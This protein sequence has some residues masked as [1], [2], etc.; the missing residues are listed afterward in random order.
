MSRPFTKLVIL[1]NVPSSQ[2]LLWV[3]SN[4]S[5]EPSRLEIQFQN[6]EIYQSKQHDIIAY[7]RTRTVA[8]HRFN[9]NNSY[10]FY[11][12]PNIWLSYPGIARGRSSNPPP[13]QTDSRE[14]TAVL[15]CCC[16]P[17]GL[18]LLLIL[19][20]TTYGCSTIP[21][22]STFV[23][24]FPVILF[25]PNDYITGV[26]AIT[27]PCGVRKWINCIVGVVRCLSIWMQQR[28]EYWFYVRRIPFMQLPAFK[29]LLPPNTLC[30]GYD[31]WYRIWC[32]IL[33]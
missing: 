16:F 32:S 14:Y 13:F 11:V 2:T 24:R 6:A 17:N 9:T 1:K 30:K 28:V 18:L 27:L 22:Q 5:S 31:N 12:K 25:P 29:L 20:Q 7:I 8:R 33:L 15:C 19:F 10:W 26:D 21:F 3:I 4:V 23:P